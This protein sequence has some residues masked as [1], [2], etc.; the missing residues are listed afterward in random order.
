MGSL[1]LKSRHRVLCGNS[2]TEADWEVLMRGAVGV[3]AFADPP[4]DLVGSDFMP[5]VERYTTDA[6][7]FVMCDDRQVQGILAA[8]DMVCGRFFVM[9]VNFCV[10]HGFDAY[11]QHILVARLSNGTPCQMKILGDGLR[12]IMPMKYRGLIGADVREDH[13]HQKPLDPLLAFASHYTSEGDLVL[14]PFLGSGTTLI[15]AEQL[16]RK[17]YGLEIS[18]AYCDVIVNRWEKLTGEQA[19]NEKTGDLFPVA[20]A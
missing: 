20:E 8:T 9:N 14:D 10:P 11:V 15:A 16:G 17:C 6:H 4:Y 3:M 18:P 7:I 2:A 5:L 1:K 12:S 19:V 13:P